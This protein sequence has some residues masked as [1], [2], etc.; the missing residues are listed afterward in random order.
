MTGRAGSALV[1]A[2]N[3]VWQFSRVKAG[4]YESGRAQSSH[5]GGPVHHDCGALGATA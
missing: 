2:H 1:D 4:M 5:V 3:E